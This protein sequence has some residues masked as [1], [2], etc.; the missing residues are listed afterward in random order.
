MMNLVSNFEYIFVII[1][2]FNRGQVLKFGA[3]SRQG[4]NKLR[5][6]IDECDVIRFVSMT[7]LG[8]S[9]APRLSY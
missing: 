2:F 5:N 3:P 9:T 1:M 4:R 6:K 7:S 8:S